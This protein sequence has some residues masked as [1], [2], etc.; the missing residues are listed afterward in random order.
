MPSRI[1]CPICG[2][3]GRAQRCHCGNARRTGNPY[4]HRQFCPICWKEGR[5]MRQ[6]EVPGDIERV[7]LEGGNHLLVYVC[8]E[9]KHAWAAD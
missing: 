1:H 8:Y 5:L 6:G 4:Q 2:Y 3:T 7:F 9:C